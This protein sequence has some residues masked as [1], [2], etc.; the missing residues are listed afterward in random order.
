M[1][2][3]EAPDPWGESSEL[4]FLEPDLGHLGQ[5]SLDVPLKVAADGV[6]LDP[7]VGQ[8]AGEPGS[9]GAREP[10]SQ[11]YPDKKIPAFH[12]SFRFMASTASAT[13]RAVMAM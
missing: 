6:E 2:R 5:G 9:Q 1:A 3:S 12:S 4:D 13:A 8:G 10:G 11:T 7:D